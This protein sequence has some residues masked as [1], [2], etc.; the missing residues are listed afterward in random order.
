MSSIDHSKLTLAN[1]KAGQLDQDFP[2]LKK[3]SSI[4]ENTPWHLNQSVLDHTVAV[5]S[6]FEKLEKKGFVDLPESDKLQA[7]FSQK[8]A[9]ISKSELIIMVM[10]F[11]D[12]GK[13]YTLVENTEGNRSCPGHEIVS[14]GI[15]KKALKKTTLK[16]IHQEWVLKAISMHG[17]IHNLIDTKI[18]RNDNEFLE[19][20]KE[21]LGAQ[22]LDL[23]V[24]YYCDIL[25]G[26]LEKTNKKAFRQRLKT[27][28]E[29]IQYVSTSY[30]FN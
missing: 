18:G 8:I 28:E 1:F 11:H 22:I 27:T 9:G 21:V 17:Q 4:I 23:L 15:A 25:G 30:L 3:L 10:I 12:A 26:D 19:K 14:V 20:S 5:L 16:E 24:F 2:I 7:Y 29:L 6:A 13:V